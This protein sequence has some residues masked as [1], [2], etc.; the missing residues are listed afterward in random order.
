MH[1]QN[2][3]CYLRNFMAV[4]T[5]EFVLYMLLIRYTGCKVTANHC[6]SQQHTDSVSIRTSIMGLHPFHGVK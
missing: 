4:R 6:V 5:W 1:I 3:V 2:Q